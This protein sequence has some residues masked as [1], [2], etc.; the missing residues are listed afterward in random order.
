MRTSPICLS[1]RSETSIWSEA[2][3]EAVELSAVGD[4]MRSALLARG[5]TFF[6]ELATE[7]RL[8]DTQAEDTLAELVSAGVVTADS[9]AGLRA[10]LVP[11][12][13]RPSSGRRHKLGGP[14]TVE[15]AGRW[16]LL[17]CAEAAWS[18]ADVERLARRLLARW[19]VVFRVIARRESTVGWRR[20]LAAYRAMEA[21]GEV[22]GGRFVTGV[23][24][25]QFALAEAV[26]ALRRTR[27]AAADGELVAISAC[28]PLNLTGILL[29]D[30][31]VPAT[32]TNRIVFRDGVPVA[33]LEGREIRYLDP[34]AGPEVER[35]L[36]RKP[37]TPRLLSRVR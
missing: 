15:S 12:S 7:C 31:R 26:T 33:V 30:A 35:A 14:Y 3:S 17:D 18:D 37:N 8:L 22:R 11:Q 1:L 32:L 28:D 16:S 27:R 10:L 13:K 5:A 24:G 34:D 23:G 6:G 20:L 19:G 36:V 21:R 4:R 9:F 29:G 25:E 2:S